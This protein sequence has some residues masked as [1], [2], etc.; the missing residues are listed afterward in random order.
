MTGR[1]AG[2]VICALVATLLTAAAPAARAPHDLALNILPPGESGTGGAH[3]TDQLKLYDALTPLRG[4]V[5]A[6]TLT[7]L[8][9]P[10]TL[11]PSGPKKLEAVPRAQ[12]KI[13][14]DRRG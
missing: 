11:G 12:V 5:T 8:F 1:A 6:K 13:Y 9:K 3:S 4:N 7:R 2:V 14:R 10:E